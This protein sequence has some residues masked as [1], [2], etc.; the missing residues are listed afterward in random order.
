MIDL[1]ALSWSFRRALGARCGRRL[2][3]LLLRAVLGR[4]SLVGVPFPRRDRGRRHTS[5]RGSIGS[6]G[7]F[8][9]QTVAWERLSA[10]MP[11]SEARRLAWLVFYDCQGAKKQLGV[12]PSTFCGGTLGE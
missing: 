4:M 10:G 1:P 7:S 8:R 9:H 11:V 6:L 2:L 12:R 3:S 5:S